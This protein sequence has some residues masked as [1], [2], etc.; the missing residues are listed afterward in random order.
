[1]TTSR[2]LLPSEL[3]QSLLDANRQQPL[4]DILQQKHNTFG[5]GYTPSVEEEKNTPEF[6]PIRDIVHVD[7]HESFEPSECTLVETFRRKNSKKRKSPDSDT[8][9]FNEKLRGELF[10]CKVFCLFFSHSNRAK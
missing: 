5:I 8:S 6:D 3:L 1:M 7:I 10:R 9:L 4:T 2:G